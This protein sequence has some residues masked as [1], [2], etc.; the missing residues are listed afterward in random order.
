MYVCTEP[1]AI[2]SKKAKENKRRDNFIK[3]THEADQTESRENENIQ[4][5][6]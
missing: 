2:T 3:S 6:N 5:V 4:K 1:F